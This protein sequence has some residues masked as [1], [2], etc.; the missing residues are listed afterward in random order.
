[1]ADCEYPDINSTPTKEWIEDK[2]ALAYFWGIAAGKSNMAQETR[3]TPC[4]H[5]KVNWELVGGEKTV[6]CS[7]CGE[8][9]KEK[10][11]DNSTKAVIVKKYPSRTCGFC[12]GVQVW[13]AECG[14]YNCLN[15]PKVQLREPDHECETIQRLS[16]AYR[17]NKTEIEE[18][19]P[20]FRG[21][22]SMGPR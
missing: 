13:D 8:T 2:D 20:R 19:K 6:W 21:T 17:E 5:P 10:L 14:V 15:C 11:L 9:V 7:S 1:M 16:E 12:F 4:S 18:S 22:N 3:K